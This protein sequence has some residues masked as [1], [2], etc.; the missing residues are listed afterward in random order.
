MNYI[1]PFSAVVIGFLL[2]VFFK[3]KENKYVKLLLS[4]SGAYL[5][6]LTVFTLLPEVYHLHGEHNHNALKHTGIFILL[7]ILLQIVLEFFS[8]GAE[9]GHIHTHSQP[10]KSFPIA[11]F[12]SLSIHSLLEGFPLTHSHE[13]VYG[14]FVHKLPIAFVLSAFFI[15]TGVSKL[16]TAG[17]LFLFG[18]MTPLGTFLSDYVPFLANYH[19][20]LSAMVIGIFLHISTM[21][22]FESA[23]GHKFNSFKMMSILLGFLIAYFT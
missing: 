17:F 18:L 14:I 15:N 1:L 12:I 11:L 16:K 13:L 4:F 8:Q 23:E 19:T 22:L 9:H 10:Q 7:G 20:E 3:P 21:I 6:G 5:L 2:A